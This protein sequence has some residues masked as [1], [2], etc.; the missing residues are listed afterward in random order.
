MFGYILSQR[1]LFDIEKGR[2]TDIRS[3]IS[4]SS[5]RCIV[6]RRTMV[7][8]LAYLLER[9]SDKTIPIDEILYY[10]WDKNHLQSS[11]QRLWQVMKALKSKLEMAGIKDDFIIRKDKQSYMIIKDLVTPLYVYER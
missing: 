7:S 9:R 2:L 11:T 4:E 3:P 8:L 6:M 5:A 1:V 10:V